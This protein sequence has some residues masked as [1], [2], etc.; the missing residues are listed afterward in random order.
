MKVVLGKNFNPSFD[1]KVQRQKN[2]KY[3]GMK[4]NIFEANMDE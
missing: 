4:L 1:K 3:N 2:P